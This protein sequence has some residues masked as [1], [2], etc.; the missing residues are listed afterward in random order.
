M[1]DNGSGGAGFPVRSVILF[2][3]LPVIV[4]IIA[5]ATLLRANFNELPLGTPL[6]NLP[7]AEATATQAVSAGSRD[8]ED[9]YQ[10]GLEAYQRGDYQQAIVL[11][12]AVAEEAPDSAIVY[13]S[14]GLAYFQIG[15]SESAAQAFQQAIT[16]DWNHPMAQFNLAESL[17][18]LGRLDEAEAAFRE[19]I[20]QNPG[21]AAAHYGLATLLRSEGRAEEA[22][23]A[24]LAAT[25]ADDSFIGAYVELALLY[26]GAQDWQSAETILEKGRA[27]VP[28]SL[29]I[30]YNLAVAYATQGK[31]RLARLLF[32]SIT[33]SDPGGTWGNL[34]SQALNNLGSSSST[35]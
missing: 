10:A 32:T 5:F 18:D 25:E 30:Q 14:L 6:V 12:Q 11:F 34:A 29:E 27:A 21:L 19:A 1:T 2:M 15:D 9:S 35:R 3:I 16:L 8:L 4:T 23:S 33:A 24:Y 26:A 20:R 13:N 17:L 28:D 7:T 22:E 31:M